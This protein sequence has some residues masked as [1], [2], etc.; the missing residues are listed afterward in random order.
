MWMKTLMNIMKIKRKEEKKVVKPKV[1][2]INLSFRNV[3]C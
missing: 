1:N 2:E 3:N